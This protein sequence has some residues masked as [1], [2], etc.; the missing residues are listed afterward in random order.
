VNCLN[1]RSISK[2]DGL[3]L[4]KKKIFFGILLALFV[5]LYNFIWIDKTFTMSE[6]WAQ[7]YN[8]LLDQGKVPYRDF[9]YYMPPLNLL[10]DYVIWKLSFGY[11][12]IYR[13]WRLAER[14]L[15]VELMYSILIQK[16]KP[17]I[18][19]VGCFIGAVLGS[20]TVFDLGGD[21]NQLQQLL[22]ALICY[23][24]LKYVDYIDNP[25][26][27]Y[28]WAFIT[29][30]IGGLM[31]LTKQPLVLASGVCFMIMLIIFW[32]T[33]KEKH[34]FKTVG[35][36]ILGALI[37][38]TIAGIYLV[39]NKAFSGFIYQVFIDTSSKGTLFDIVIKRLL[40]AFKANFI[41]IIGI[42]LGFL[43]Y[44]NSKNRKIKIEYINF[45]MISLMVIC[46]SYYIWDILYH[47]QD[48]AR[49]IIIILFAV[50]FIFCFFLNIFKLTRKFSL[51]ILISIITG[52]LFANVKNITY[53]IY[54][55]S[56]LFDA[57]PKFLTLIF[58]FFAIWIIYRLI[59]QIM[60]RE[61]LDYSGM[62]VAFAG[63][64]SGYATIMPSGGI[65]VVPSC[66][67]VLFPAFIYLL[68]R[69]QKQ[70]SFLF[71]SFFEGVVIVLFA[72]CLSQK[73]VTPYTWWGDTEASIWDKNEKVNI[74]ALKGFKFS[75][76]E[77]K[78]Y[79]DLNRI[80]EK[81]TN[82]DSTIWGFPY[83]KV[84]NIFQNNYNMNGFV[85]VEFYDVCADDYAIEEAALLAK[86]PPNIVVWQDI[87]DAME[88]HEDVYRGGN[89]LGQREIQKWF[90]SV[91]DTDYEL[92][93]QVDNVFVYKLKDG[94][95]ITETFIERKTA[96]NTTANYVD[97]V[98]EVVN[99]IE[100][101][102]TGTIEDPYLISSIEDLEY[103]RDSVN[104]GTS[105]NGQF[106]KQTEDIDLS[107]IHNWNPIGHFESGRF[108]EGNYNGNGY[109]I[110][111]L[112]I[113]KGQ[114]NAGLFGQL[115]GTVENINL[116]NCDING[117]FVG[118][119]TSQGAASTR[120]VNCLVTG[121][122][123]GKGRAGGIVDNLGGGSII[124]CVADVEL[125]GGITAGISG[126]YQTIV[127]NCFSNTSN[128]VSIDD[129]L[130][131][132]KDT[133]NKLNEY[134]NQLKEE[135]YGSL[136][137]KW[138]VHEGIPMVAVGK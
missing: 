64:A 40:K 43:I 55:N 34:I 53:G 91:K 133:E 101:E 123:D 88:L 25:K 117:D 31:F 15:I 8:G 137:N 136:L 70:I 83:T 13:L 3:S 92:I 116:I 21:Y 14:I 66:S 130:R 80:I 24:L 102:G 27:K 65:G 74:A 46:G 23:S 104:S 129:G 45:F 50:I 9:Y 5:I 77:K 103:F 119:I 11:F 85:P 108:F 30:I 33:K 61:S 10:N 57:I 90:S 126:Y 47:W 112:K 32:V 121:K 86:N 114:N 48:S 79:E 107:E 26:R 84:Y 67:F 22:I 99:K 42:C 113:K 20:A 59:V 124:N 37:P 135:Y 35:Y 4:K 19:F 72:I 100:L 125:E 63:F 36:V 110:E 41:G 68:F 118:G 58:C 56:P 122:L 81:N 6:G 109:K 78:K 2:K 94:Q 38:L 51:F 105:F 106:I 18:A 134:R 7:F 93:G 1:L 98:P 120:I 69:N 111:N 95:P 16:V 17:S 76:L 28:F 75:S 62:V 132:T 71:N 128:G 44:W 138:I 127:T 96:E 29:G 39:A 97:P 87:P 131:I 60:G 49:S 12:F 54:P 82:K 52:I 89:P 73:F 115:I